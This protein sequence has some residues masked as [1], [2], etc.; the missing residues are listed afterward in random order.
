[1]HTLQ[2]VARDFEDATNFFV[3]YDGWEQWNILNMTGSPITNGSPT[4]PIHIHLIRFQ[5][6]SRDAYDTSPFDMNVGGTTSPVSYT[7]T[8]PD[9]PSEK[10]WKDVIQV[11]QGQM[12][13]VAGQ[14]GGGTGQFMYHCHIL[15]HEDEGMMRPFEV[16][17]AQVMKVDPHMG[18]GSH[19]HTSVHRVTPGPA[20]GGPVPGQPASDE[21]HQK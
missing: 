12:V 15:Q 7:R 5:L 9:D 19:E 17:P 14:F 3:E 2:R 4:H 18:G 6:L 20:L 11:P 21:H 10:G 1:V 8:L 16:F 13:H